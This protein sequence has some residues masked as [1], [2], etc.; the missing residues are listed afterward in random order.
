MLE[1]LLYSHSSPPFPNIQLIWHCPYRLIPKQPLRMY[2]AK[3]YALLYF[4]FLLGNSEIFF[5][6]SSYLSFNFSLWLNK[7]DLQEIIFTASSF[8]ADLFDLLLSKVFFVLM[9]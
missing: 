4:C 3:L 5:W 9:H 7:A 8:Y 6:I 1:I 2:T